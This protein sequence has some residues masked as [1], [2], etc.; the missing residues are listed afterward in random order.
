M[1]CTSCSWIPA[2]AGGL[3]GGSCPVPWS[4]GSSGGSACGMS[5][6]GG[7][8][9]PGGGGAG[10][11]HGLGFH[12]LLGPC[13]GGPGGFLSLS[14]PS[15]SGPLFLGPVVGG[16]GGLVFRKITCGLRGAGSSIGPD[17]SPPMNTMIEYCRMSIS[18]PSFKNTGNATTASDRC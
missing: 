1:S 4:I 18:I 17:N 10:G 15:S 13:F 5:S 9:E 14:F 11:C 12:G 8:E 16:L 7:P 2:P 6:S 3:S